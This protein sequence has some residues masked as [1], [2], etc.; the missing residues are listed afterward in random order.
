MDAHTEM[1]WQ[2]GS[3]RQIM[4]EAHKRFQDTLEDSPEAARVALASAHY[5]VAKR[6]LR[7]WWQR[8]LA[9]WHM[10]QA[11]SH[12]EIVCELRDLGWFKF[13][14]DQVDV[15]ATI[16]SKVPSWLGGNSERARRYL[17]DALWRH[18]DE[19]PMKP[20][21]RAL[22]LITLGGIES[23]RVGVSQAKEYYE[24]ARKLIPEIETEDSPDRERQLVRVMA[25]V[26][27]FEYDHEL[28]KYFAR[29][30]I[31]RAR[32]LAEKVSPDQA[33]KIR[34]ECLRRGI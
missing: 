34:A 27:F 3:A 10:L 28:E 4:R 22:M 8:P 19:Y 24:R 33:E 12:A 21:T 5:S 20:H 32:D 13:T 16:L 25:G 2:R 17:E 9:A 18:D 11:A 29:K 26:A 15:I 23:R 6:Y 1:I 14:A 31:G 7:F 30:M